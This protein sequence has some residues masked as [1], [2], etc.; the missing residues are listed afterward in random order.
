MD[1]IKNTFRRMI[2][3]NHLTDWD[4]N[5]YR[6]WDPKN[7]A[8]NIEK[9]KVKAAIIYAHDIEGS[10]W[11]NTAH[12]HK[13]RGLGDCDQLAL[14]TDELHKRGIKVIA[15]ITLT[16]ENKLFREHPEWRNKFVDGSECFWWEEGSAD[17]W[18]NLC[19]NSPLREIIMKDVKEI[20]SNYDVDG[21][22]LDMPNFPPTG[23]SCYCKYCKEKFKEEFGEDIPTEADW[24]NPLWRKFIL[25]RYRTITDLIK[26]ITDLAHSI[27]PDI[28]VESQFIAGFHMGWEPGNSVRIG[29]VA[30]CIGTDSA[31]GSGLLGASIITKIMRA[32]SDKPPEVFSPRQPLGLHNDY[33]LKP[34]NHLRAEFFSAIANGGQASFI[35][36]IHP[37]G[38]LQEIVYETVGKIY[39]EIE[40]REEWLIDAESSNYAAVYF[41]EAS[42]DFYGRDKPQRYLLSF[43]G[44][45]KALVE[46]HIPF[47]I[48]L[49]RHINKE[50][51][52]KYSL[53][54]LPNVACLSDEQI[55]AIREYV[56]GGGGL[57]ATY[58]TSTMIWFGDRREDFGLADVFG[59]NYIEPLVSHTQSYLK[60]SGRH[61]VTEDVSG[62][63]PIPFWGKGQQIRVK[64]RA[65]AEVLAKIVLPY[66]EPTRERFI[67][68]S[69]PPAVET[70]DP[71]IVANRYGEGRVVYIAGQLDG[72]YLIAGYPDCRKIIVNAARWVAGEELPLTVEAP[73]SVEVTFFKQSK[74]NRF[75]IHLVNFQTEVGRNVFTYG[76]G[77]ENHHL[78]EEVLPVYNIKVKMKIPE[79]QKIKKVY[80]APEREEL[81]YEKLGSY[82]ELTVPKMEEVHKMVI[83]EFS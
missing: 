12:G 63:I 45:C 15:Y 31:A 54:V 64:P 81:P 70:D 36:Q 16:W 1:W 25:W 69:N 7:V 23:Q 41:S 40:E 22:F 46:G 17:A 24:D 28:I 58:E 51:L 60:V 38:T 2:L 68:H 8:E 77:K 26:E 18:T 20:V 42:R 9:A 73:R 83:V 57:L 62:D 59:V 27:K 32:A 4:P 72:R 55:A 43:N 5:F 3:D 50:S 78:I 76:T 29:E 11:Y 13:H 82:I 75:V 79:G 6:K 34:I 35:D 37:D 19:H 10:Y 65:G 74:L 49:D 80:L 47:D 39:S 33:H 21:L 53:L 61:P 67:S 71:A 66:H 48:V 14:L 44:I 56:K 30:D 52:S